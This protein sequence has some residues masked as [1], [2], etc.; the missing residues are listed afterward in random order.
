MELTNINPSLC[1]GHL[2]A[3]EFRAVTDDG[4]G[5]V[6]G[7]VHGTVPCI[8]CGT[9]KCLSCK[10]L[11]EVINNVFLCMWCQYSSYTYHLGCV[12]NP[13]A[14]MFWYHLVSFIYIYIYIN[15]YLDV[16]STSRCACVNILIG[17]LFR[18]TLDS[19]WMHFTLYDFTSCFLGSRE[20]TS[21]R[22]S[23]SR[24]R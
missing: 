18:H 10:C 7:V 23:G 3:A 17:G 5:D 15:V 2:C 20:M 8:L 4:D 1:K 22:C 12:S 13:C 6:V 21:E 16:C 24:V 11:V 19:I 9:N 14:H